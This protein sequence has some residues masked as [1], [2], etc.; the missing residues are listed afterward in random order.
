MGAGRD[1]REYASGEKSAR[2]CQIRFE[3][4]A[5]PATRRDHPKGDFATLKCFQQKQAKQRKERHAEI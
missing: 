3:A 1:E 2:G 5:M 4:D